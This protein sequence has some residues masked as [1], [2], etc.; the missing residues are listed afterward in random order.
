MRFEGDKV[1]VSFFPHGLKL[2]HSNPIERRLLLYFSL[3][4]RKHV[5]TS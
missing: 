4:V 5:C 3:V 1:Q 2:A